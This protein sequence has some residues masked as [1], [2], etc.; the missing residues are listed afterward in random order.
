MISPTTITRGTPTRTMIPVLTQSAPE[1]VETEPEDVRLSLLAQGDSGT[2]KTEGIRRLLLAGYNVVVLAIEAKMQR[3]LALRPQT[4]YIDGPVIERV[5]GT[6]RPPTIDE[7]YQR[8]IAFKEAL[9]EGKYRE[10]KGKPIDIIAGDGVM[11]VMDIIK[12]YRL[13]NIPIS[14]STGEKNTY[15]AYDQ[16]GTDGVDFIKACKVAASEVSRQYGMPPVGMYWTCGEEYEPAAGKYVPILPGRIAP[17]ALPYQFEA[18]LRLAV[19][20]GADGQPVF[21]AH[22]V[23][24]EQWVAK[25]PPG[26][27]DSRIAGPVG[28]GAPDM[29]V[30]WK[31]LLD[32]YM[33]GEADK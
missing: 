32:Y 10:H 13:K 6:K 4:V 19:E 8:L 11:E 12:A 2:G 30:I 16:I 22:T 26:V 28:A 29:G 21:V 7:K 18:I 24:S 9:A 27:L 5:T 14:K 17:R 33:I 31:Q 20:R 3:L 15:A 23:A 25:S 1:I